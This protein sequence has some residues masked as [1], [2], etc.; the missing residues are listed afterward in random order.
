MKKTVLLFLLLLICSALNRAGYSQSNNL[1]DS[2]KKVAITF[3]DLPFNTAL[4]ISNEVMI[5]RVDKLLTKIKSQNIPVVAFVNENK[6]EVNGKRDPE[7]IEILRKWLD[8]GIELGN[9]TYSHRSAHDISIEEYKEE[10]LKGES[11]IKELLNERNMRVR[12]FRHP[13]L[14]TGLT[15]DYKYEIEKFL[16]ERGYTIAPV[17][18]DNSEWIFDRAYNIALDSS[19]TE[20]METIGNDYV[21]Y[22][23]DKI[24]YFEGQTQKLFGRQINQILLVHSNSINSDYFD[25]LCEMIREEGYKFISLEEALK[26]GAYNSP[27]TFVENNGISWLHR[28]AITKGVNKEFFGEEPSTPE[29]IL[30]IAGLEHE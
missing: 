11:T 5:M 23:R 25:K 12:Y 2:N 28:W 14:H 22:M 1:N 3:D 27:D 19:N 15:L 4:R 21:E 20:L 6:L 17:T 7:R 30:K 13:Y 16:T 29:N 26:D 10:I 24:K 18:F 8:A 9:H